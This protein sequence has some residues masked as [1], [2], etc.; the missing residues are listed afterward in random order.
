MAYSSK[1]AD[2]ESCPY[3]FRVRPE[4]A[5]KAYVDAAIAC[6][7]WPTPL[8]SDEVAALKERVATLQAENAKLR[9][10]VRSAQ[11]YADW[12]YKELKGDGY[13]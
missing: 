1:C 8:P 12:L 5:T 2:V 3:C 11:G 4:M 6:I 9:D 10:F 13:A 7:K